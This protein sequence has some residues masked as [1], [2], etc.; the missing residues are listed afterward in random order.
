MLIFCLQPSKE[1]KRR[2]E[3]NDD[4]FNKNKD[5]LWVG[6]HVVQASPGEKVGQRCTSRGEEGEVEELAIDNSTMPV[7]QAGQPMSYMYTRTD[8]HSHSQ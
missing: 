2:K 4:I 8:R 3:D 7:N 1:V 5:V 6:G